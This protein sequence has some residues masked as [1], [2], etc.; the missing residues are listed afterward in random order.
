MIP[1]F[2]LQVVLVLSERRWRYDGRVN[3]GVWDR[4]AKEYYYYTND[5]DA[6]FTTN[7]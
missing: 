2:V 4:K 3:V 5:D 7:F 6:E 1:Q